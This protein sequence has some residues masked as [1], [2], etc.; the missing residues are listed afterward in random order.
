MYSRCRTAEWM[1]LRTSDTCQVSDENNI[2]FYFALLKFPWSSIKLTVSHTCLKKGRGY[3]RILYFIPCV[4]YS[5]I[6]DDDDDR[7]NREPCAIFCWIIMKFF[8]P[9]ARR[10]LTSIPNSRS[11]VRGGILHGKP[12]TK[13]VSVLNFFFVAR[14]AVPLSARDIFLSK[15]RDQ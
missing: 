11:Q 1:N 14:S 9:L 8:R 2:S 5:I 10:I 12:P 3:V 7:R 6:A 4:M 15:M 13:K